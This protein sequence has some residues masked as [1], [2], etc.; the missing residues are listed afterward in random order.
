[1]ARLLGFLGLFLGL[2]ARAQE[3]GLVRAKLRGGVYAALGGFRL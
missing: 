2:Q 3:F 1:M